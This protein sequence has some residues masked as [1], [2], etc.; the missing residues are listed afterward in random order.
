MTENNLLLQV[1][2]DF[3]MGPSYIVALQKP[4]IGCSHLHLPKALVEAVV[5]LEMG[6]GHEVRLH[7]CMSNLPCS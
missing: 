2:F 7:M 4:S 3:P 5:L 1:N 6:L